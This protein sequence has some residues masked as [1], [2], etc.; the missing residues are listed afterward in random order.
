MPGRSRFLECL[1]L[2]LVFLPLGAHAAEIAI[3]QSRPIE[4]LDADGRPS[5]VSMAQVGAH[6]TLVKQEGAGLVVQDETGSRYLIPADA[7]DYTPPAASVTAPAHPPAAGTAAA[8]NAPPG[9]ATNAAPDATAA[10]PPPAITKA[11]TAPTAPALAANLSPDDAA[12]I[13]QLNDALGLPFFVDTQ[14]WQDD[15]DAVAKRLQWPQESKTTTQESYR[16]YADANE[17]DILGASAYS[18]ALYGK[19]GAPTYISIIFANA[20]DFPEA[21]ALGGNL[22][23]VGDDTIAKVTKDLAAAVTKD[24]GTISDKLTAILGDPVVTQYGNSSSN[25][26]EVHRWDWNDVAFLLNSHNGEYASIKI[27]PTDV[28]DHHGVVDVTDRD[29]MRDLLAQRVVKRDNGDVI[30]SEIP[31]VDQGPKGYCVPATWERYLRYMDVPAD[32]Y[33]LAIMGHTGFGGGTSVEEMQAGVDDYV[34]A[35]HRR[36]EIYDAPLDVS[37]IAKYI[38]QGLPLMWTCWVVKQVEIQTFQHTHDRR[39]VTDWSKYTVSLKADDA[40]LGA[41]Y[42]PDDNRSNGHMR[43]IIGYNTA[44]NEIA[45]SDSWGPAAAER[46]MYAPTALKISQGQL[47]YLSW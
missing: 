43:L 34:S 19:N 39:A 40:A 32:L 37:H 16:R 31:M 25:R 29:A 5:A 10:T 35:Y 36:I 2:G 27:I 41:L 47:S 42:A 22:S 13:K 33:V 24:A 23:L 4:K 14:F 12:K 18:L 38:D 9:S 3:T 6:Y 17:A 44:T 28:A 7:T 11:A 46:W 8:T 26:D 15:V 45:I 21:R 30:L 20:G 1:L